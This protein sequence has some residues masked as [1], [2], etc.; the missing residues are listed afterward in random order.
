MVKAKV[1]V[2]KSGG[3]GG[4]DSKKGHSLLGSILMRLSPLALLATLKPISDTVGILL[5][6]ATIGVLGLLKF[7]KEFPSIIAQIWENIV[8]LL[9]LGWDILKE[10][11]IELRDTIVSTVT[12]WW[13]KAIDWLKALPGRI[14]DF[15]TALPGMI[16]ELLKTGFNFLVETFI[17]VGEFL[18][19][20]L[21]LLKETF[22]NVITNLKDRLV[23]GVRILKE[24]VIKLF[25]TT[26]EG[27]KNLIVGIK[28]LP[29]FLWEKIKL[30]FQWIVDKVQNVVDWIK[31]LPQ[32]IW[33]KLK[34]L[35]QIISDAIS[36]IFNF[37][38]PFKKKKKVDDAIIKP[39]GQI[40]ETNPNDTIIATQ[41]PQQFGGSTVINFFGITMDEAIEK[42]RV[43]FGADI[44]RASRF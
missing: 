35:G 32:L 23:N 42:I 17:R 20:K 26:K 22:I 19:E 11:F 14:W 39:G 1:N 38:N 33:N 7:F 2:N 40:I 18:R 31:R 36:N 25:E 5:A 12:E 34:G 15:I 43:E 4:T 9:K 44:V 3:G 24:K 37:V 16:W 28:A 29:G 8:A 10:K 27:L 41:N 6:F 30:G 21:L 13:G